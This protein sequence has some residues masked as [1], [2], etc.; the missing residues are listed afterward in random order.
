VRAS[1]QPAASWTRQLELTLTITNSDEIWR[2]DSCWFGIDEADH[3]GTKRVECEETSST[4]FNSHVTQFFLQDTHRDQVPNLIST[5]A[6]HV[7]SQPFL[8]TNSEFDLRS[9]VHSE[10]APK[11]PGSLHSCRLDIHRLSSFLASTAH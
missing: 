2:S 8:E 7:F 11:H 10:V 1:T 6:L 5:R 3:V 9:A 4:C